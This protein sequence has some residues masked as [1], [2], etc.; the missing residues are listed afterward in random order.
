MCIRDRYQR[1]VRG[2]GP[3]L[4]GHGQAGLACLLGY[5]L[6]VAAD[7]TCTS[8][9]SSAVSSLR[10]SLTKERDPLEFKHGPSWKVQ[11]DPGLRDQPASLLLELVAD[12]LLVGLLSQS[13]FD[14]LQRALEQIPLAL[15]RGLV[16]EDRLVGD[17]PPVDFSLHVTHNRGCVQALAGTCERISHLT[18]RS[19]IWSQLH[20]FAR[21]SWVPSAQEYI[22][23][24]SEGEPAVVERPSPR[25]RTRSRMPSSA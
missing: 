19:R 7:S 20:Q 15:T 2:T 25:D 23:P 9:L 22:Y 11:E 24:E 5:L 6:S 17:D 4:M 14:M 8:N 13:R 16:L 3:R 18:Q 21:E 10:A 12:H 1:R